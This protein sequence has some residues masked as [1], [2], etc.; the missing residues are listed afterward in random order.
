[1]PGTG[2]VPRNP[3]FGASFA[4]SLSRVL[5]PLARGSLAGAPSGALS[6]PGGVWGGLVV[7]TRAGIRVGK[8]PALEGFLGIPPSAPALDYP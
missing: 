1:M 7:S 3:S 2:R 5:G 8:C 6:S 4:A